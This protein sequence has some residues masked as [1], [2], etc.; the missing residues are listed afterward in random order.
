MAMQKIRTMAL[1]FM[2]AG[3]GGCVHY[4]TEK[5]A[6]VDQRPQIS[7]RFN[8]GDG[9]IGESRVLV[10]GLDAGRTGDFVDGRAALRVLPGTHIIQVVLG[11]RALLMERA[12][13]S[14]GAV[15]AFNLK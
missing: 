1:A 2:L 7:F 4:P 10:D 9:S 13:L 3:L 14:D 8:Q 15:R 11:D 12:Y 6:V 5:Q